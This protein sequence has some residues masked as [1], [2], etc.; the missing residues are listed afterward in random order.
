MGQDKYISFVFSFR[1]YYIRV[2]STGN[3]QYNQNNYMN[4]K[5]VCTHRIV[6]PE[7]FH[8]SHHLEENSLQII[9]HFVFG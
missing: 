1:L 7:M 5:P 4:T 6:K 8:L 2:P 9:L 3:N